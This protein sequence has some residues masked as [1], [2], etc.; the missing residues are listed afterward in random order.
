[1]P[2]GW[3]ASPGADFI[4]TS[5]GERCQGSGYAIWRGHLETAKFY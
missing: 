2:D 4:G 1:M 5:P 3:D